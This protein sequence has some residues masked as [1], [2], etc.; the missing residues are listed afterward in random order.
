MPTYALSSRNQFRSPS[1]AVGEPPDG[2]GGMQTLAKDIDDRI[3]T[4]GAEWCQNAAA[5]DAIPAARLFPG[6]LAYVAT[7]DTFYRYSG[8][9][10]WTQWDSDWLAYTPNF[11]AGVTVGNGSFSGCSWHIAGRTMRLVGRFTLGSSSAVGGTS[12]LAVPNTPAL[13]RSNGDPILGAVSFIDTSAGTTFSGDATMQPNGIAFSARTVAGSVV[14]ASS[15][16]A[17]NPLPWASTDVMSW[18]LSIPLA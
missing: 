2:P 17:S 4:G 9:G 5:R 16:S 3:G 12:R 7:N 1:G 15:L 11:T 10:A 13:F 6:K 8:A 14:T 18:D